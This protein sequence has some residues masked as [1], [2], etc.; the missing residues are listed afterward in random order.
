MA[1]KVVITIKINT[2]TAEIASVVA[3]HKTL[4]GV[5]N[6]ISF[7]SREEASSRV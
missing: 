5:F 7:L 6:V 3:V 2:P 1:A 4:K